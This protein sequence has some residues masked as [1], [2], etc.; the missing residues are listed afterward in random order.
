MAD[1][2]GRSES[3]GEGRPR[4]VSA[5][6]RVAAVEDYF[7]SSTFLVFAIIILAA[8]VNSSRERKKSLLPGQCMYYPFLTGP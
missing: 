8:S 4:I 1:C 2:H 3:C 5:L 6:V 7:V